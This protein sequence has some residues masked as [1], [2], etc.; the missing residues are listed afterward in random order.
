MGNLV[1]GYEAPFNGFSNSLSDVE[2][3]NAAIS[4][5]AYRIITHRF[6]QSPGYQSIL[7]KCNTLMSLLNYNIENHDI[8]NNGED[9][10]ALGNYIAEKYISYGL[11]DGAM[12]QVDYV[13][14]YAILKP[15]FVSTI[16]FN[17]TFPFSDN[18][19]EL[20]KIQ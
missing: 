11:Q 7:S 9:P 10:I 1:H 13:N 5:A 14:Q 4:Y 2:N 17:L 12:E 19:F 16:V 6:S 15:L 20:I 3:N 18:L 8:D